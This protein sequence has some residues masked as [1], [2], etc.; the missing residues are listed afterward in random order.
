MSTQTL[1]ETLVE[2]HGLAR[3]TTINSLSLTNDS[4][5]STA[6]T[7]WGPG[8]VMGRVLLGFG[9][10]VKDGIDNI[11]IRRRLSSLNSSFP[12]EETLPSKHLDQ[13]Y[14]DVLELSRYVPRLPLEYSNK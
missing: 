11:I 5:R 1:T 13:I 4:S 12:H 2:D 14:D 7:E 8:T 10:A 3:I 9:E 6:S